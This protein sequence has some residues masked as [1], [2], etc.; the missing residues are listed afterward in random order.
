MTTRRKHK[1]TSGSIPRMPTGIPGF[2]LLAMGGLSKDRMT[3]IEG[4][5]GSGKA[6][7]I[8][9]FLAEGIL[10]YDQPGVFVTL[11][12]QPGDVRGAMLS[13][14]WDVARWEAEGK[15][16]FIDGTAAD[17][18]DVTVGEYDLGGLV[19]QINAAVGTIGAKRL[20]ID[21]VGAL[22]TRFSDRARVRFE[23]FRISRMLRTMDVTSVISSERTADYGEGGYRWGEEFVVDN[24]VILRNVLEAEVRRRTLEILKMRGVAHRRG[25]FPFVITDGSGIEV[26]PLSA[27]HLEHKSSNV[28]AT[29]G[30]AGLDDM[31]D[32]G[33]FRDSTT[34]VSGPTGAGKTLVATEFACGAVTNG[35]RCLFLGFEESRDQLVRNAAGWGRDF[36]KMESEGL[37]HIVCEYPESM[38][39][40]D[41]LI[42]IKGLIGSFRPH[43]IVLDSLT[44]LGRLASEKSL[45][46][47]ILGLTAYIKQLQVPALFT[48]TS[49]PIFGATSRITETQLTTFTDSIILL[50]Y[51]EYVGVMRH[52]V[53][54]LKMRGSRHDTAIR[55]FTIDSTGLHVGEQFREPYDSTLFSSRT[56]AADGIGIEKSAGEHNE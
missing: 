7:F 55:E 1:E 43:R 49:E 8:A 33:P 14:G 17:E 18:E 16:A 32:G 48:A 56:L 35:E 51:M 54:V 9:Q 31:C 2:D 47:F 22:F 19:A 29:F 38:N 39:L 24:V 53:T 10:Q 37:L 41:R 12:E 30:N 40:E 27:I 36:A 11:E 21:A 28:R 45:R 42:M 20:A 34:L 25:E 5:P 44:S 50:R 4:T 46:D 23:L 52:G 15:W 13:L 6:I 3:M 26:M